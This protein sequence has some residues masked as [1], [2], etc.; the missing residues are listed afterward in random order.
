MTILI[1]EPDPAAQKAARALAAAAFPEATIACVPS[2][3]VLVAVRGG[4]AYEE[5]IPDGV[6]V[7][8]VD[9]DNLED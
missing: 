6:E 2:L 3:K 8:I 9:H 5:S 4:I 7:E 1:S